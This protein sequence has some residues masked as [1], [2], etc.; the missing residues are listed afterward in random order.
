MAKFTHLMWHCTATKRGRHYDRSHIERWHLVERGWS[1]VGYSAL[2][3]LSGDFDILIP[4]DK[5][6]VIESWE[7][8]NGAKGWNG[9]TK[10]LCYVGGLDF[11]GKEPMDTRTTHQAKVMAAITK[12][13]TM[14]WPDIKV[15]G[16]NQ[17][18]PKACPSFDVPDWC[19]Q[20]GIPEKN[21]D[22]GFYT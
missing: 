22:W 21:I 12:I 1:R 20:I 9:R 16:H 14:L 18:S 8:S 15:I 10:H 13:Y 19:E 11:Y 4:H 7:L 3:L 2:V 17:V 6:D 5:D